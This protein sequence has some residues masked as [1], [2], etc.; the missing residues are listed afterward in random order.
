MLY[1]AGGVPNL[2]MVEGVDNQKVDIYNQYYQY[3]LEI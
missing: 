2:A 1:Y 3:L